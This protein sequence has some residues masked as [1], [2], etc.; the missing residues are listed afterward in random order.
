MAL[1]NMG[2]LRMS[3]SENTEEN[4]YW[5]GSL[6]MSSSCLVSMIAT[7]ISVMQPESILESA[8]QTV[9]MANNTAIH[10]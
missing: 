5:H 8:V 2:Y 9:L 3:I 7:W 6:E 1:L 10:I 4:G